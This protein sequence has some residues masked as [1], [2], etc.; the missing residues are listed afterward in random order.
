MASNPQF[1]MV[2]NR[3][4]E[5]LGQPPILPQDP[6]RGPLSLSSQDR[7]ETGRC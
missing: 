3:Q 2:F 6:V 5:E 7:G 1:A 4:G